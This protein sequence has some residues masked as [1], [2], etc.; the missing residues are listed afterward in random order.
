MSPFTIIFFNP[1]SGLINDTNRWL[2]A[3]PPISQIQALNLDL[4]IPNKKF[5]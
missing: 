5:P 1:T 2:V 4:I 3:P